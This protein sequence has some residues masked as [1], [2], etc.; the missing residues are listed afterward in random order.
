[1]AISDQMCDELSDLNLKDPKVDPEQIKY[2]LSQVNF[3]TF[4]VPGTTAIVA[5]AIWKGFVLCQSKTACVS[6]KNFKEE[7]GVKYAIEKVK[8]KAEGEL[9]KLE[10]WRLKVDTEMNRPFLCP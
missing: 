4:K 10:G 6:T 2:L 8:K 9:W 1:M 3:E 7:F 5:F